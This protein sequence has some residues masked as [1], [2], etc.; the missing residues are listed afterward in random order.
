MRCLVFSSQI[1]RSLSLPLKSAY[2]PETR[3]WNRIRHNAR[4][5]VKRLR[6]VCRPPLCHPNDQNGQELYSLTVNINSS[7]FKTVGLFY[8]CRERSPV[9]L[10]SSRFD[11][12]A[13]EP[14]AC[15][16]TIRH[17]AWR[18]LYP[19]RAGVASVRD[20]FQRVCVENGWYFF[21]YNHLLS[22]RRTARSNRFDE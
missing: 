22:H 8:T 9:S 16:E 15:C 2:K 7:L 18:F 10:G 14:F 11:A 21:A 1:V 6:R 5:T 17:R 4:L 13:F 19:P 3:W 20:I 12:T